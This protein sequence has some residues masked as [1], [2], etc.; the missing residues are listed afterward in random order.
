MRGK[1]KN[2]P[3]SL[4]PEFQNPLS[5]FIPILNQKLRNHIRRT[6]NRRMLRWQAELMSSKK[7]KLKTLNWKE[8]NPGNQILVLGLTTCSHKIRVV[9]TLLN[10]TLDPSILQEQILIKVLDHHHLL[11]LLRRSELQAQALYLQQ[12]PCH[13]IWQAGCLLHQE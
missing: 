5:L 12:D 10:L 9:L 3:N 6:A 1:Q 13:K 11:Q 8:I 4:H 7:A 2:H